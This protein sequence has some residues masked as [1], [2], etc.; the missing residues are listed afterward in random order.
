VYEQAGAVESS[1]VEHNR[2]VL[3]GELSGLPGHL[4][5]GSPIT[6]RLS[7]GVDGRL[8]VSAVEPTSGATLC[9]DAYIDG[10]LDRAER[11][12]MA[13]GLARLAVRQ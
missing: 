5:A 4:P 10:V 6:V 13:A 7:L 8:S 12:R 2:R 9:L 11:D 1:D 3:D